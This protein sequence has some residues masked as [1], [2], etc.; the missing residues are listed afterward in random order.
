MLKELKVKNYLLID[1]L[2]LSFNEGMTV[3]T[4][5]TGAGKSIILSAINS[6]FKGRCSSSDIKKNCSEA[7]LEAIFEIDNDIIKILE[8]YEI[9]VDINEKEIIISRELSQKGSRGRINGKIISAKALQELGEIFVEIHE[10]NAQSEILS[11]KG[12]LDYL[13]SINSDVKAELKFYKEKYKIWKTLYKEIEERK[14]KMH[15]KQKEL[16][17]LKFQNDEIEALEIEDE[18]EENKIKNKILKLAN[19]EEINQKFK[20]VY[21]LFFEEEGNISN[22][23]RKCLKNLKSINNK[24]DKIQTLI[25]EFEQANNQLDNIVNELNDYSDSLSDLSEEENIDDLNARINNIQ[26]IKRKHSVQNLEEL[27]KLHDEIKLKINDLENFE[28]NLEKKENELI[29]I[30]NEIKIIAGNLTQNRIKIASSL[31]I[32]MNQ[33]LKTLGMPM[34]EFF[35]KFTKIEDFNENGLDKIDFM[36]KSNAGE[37]FGLLS[38]IGSG[39]EKSRICLLLRS[40]FSENAYSKVQKT[41]IFDEIDAG[42]SGSVSEQIGKKL[43]NL[44]LRNQVVCVTHQPLVAVFGDRHYFVYKT[45]TENITILFAKELKKDDEKVKALL[46]LMTGENDKSLA[47]DYTRKLIEKAQEYKNHE[48]NKKILINS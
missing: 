10:Q 18:E 35:V 39:G 14:V 33:E 21:N 44:S 30:Q 2:D 16:D 1:E 25:N 3:I 38:K 42:T 29:K 13:D 11:S 19:S 8:N 23:L 9:E 31:N 6:I 40:L 26:K 34:A 32:A 22:N 27:I 41:I 45:Q 12:Q 15:E 5:E 48:Q 20:T 24:E 7:Y 37:D 28:E 47:L 46:D 17:Y 4:G 43:S 36:L